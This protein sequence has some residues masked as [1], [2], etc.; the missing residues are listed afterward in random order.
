MGTSEFKILADM[1]AEVAAS[2]T[3]FVGAI[4]TILLPS[5]TTAGS[6]KISEI[7]LAKS[8]YKYWIKTNSIQVQKQLSYNYQ[9][10]VPQLE[11]KGKQNENQD[12]QEPDSELVLFMLGLRI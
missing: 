1:M 7:L 3:W 12:C 11:T 10:I 8:N 4:L 2:D 6:D 9:Q 5:F